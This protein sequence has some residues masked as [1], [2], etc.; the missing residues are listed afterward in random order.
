MDRL[1][2]PVGQVLR[3]EPH[4]QR[5]DRAWEA[6]RASRESELQPGR[7]A[8]WLRPSFAVGVACLLVGVAAGLGISAW[9]AAG[10]GAI[11]LAQGRPI[12]RLEVPDKG[13]SLAVPLSDGSQ[14]L[15]S[16][17]A[18]LQVIEN[19]KRSIRWRMDAGRATFDVNPRR[20]QHW[21]IDTGLAWVEVTG[22]RFVLER[23]ETALRVEVERGSVL[24][25][26]ERVPGR[27]ASLGPGDSLEIRAAQREN[28]VVESGAAPDRPREAAPP[29][30]AHPPK[31]E[32]APSREREPVSRHPGRTAWQK[33]VERGQRAAVYGTLGAAGYQHEVR[34]TESV[35]DLLALADIARLGG[36][37]TEAVSPLQKVLTRFPGDANASLAAFTL[38]KLELDELKHPEAAAAAFQKALALGA[39]RGLQEET[40]ARLVEAQAAAGKRDE[41]RRTADEYERR[42]PEGRYLPAIREQ[43][44]VP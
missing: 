6:I 28:P 33:M 17:G 5:L 24:V 31:R 34:R 32:P 14:V 18:S 27:I 29:V 42:F 41:A 20:E 35:D 16:G 2:I 1:P 38:G 30:P 44:S 22:T 12:D 37:P 21:M 19:T 43:R 10:R 3:E 9:L 4:E 23:G 7:G 36:H 11:T 15:L 26:G 25:I 40:F 39:P 8:A 13:E